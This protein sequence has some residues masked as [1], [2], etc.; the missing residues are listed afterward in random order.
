MNQDRAAEGARSAG[1]RA[2]Q[3]SGSSGA[4]ESAPECRP[5]YREGWHSERRDR[6]PRWFRQCG[7]QRHGTRHFSSKPA[8]YLPS[9]STPL[10]GTAQ[11]SVSLLPTASWKMIMVASKSAAWLEKEAG[12]RCC[13]HFRRTPRRSLVRF[14][15]QRLH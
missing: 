12:S 11:A 8:K 5:G 6:L 15:V 7:G 10:R 2:R 13:C 3:R 1:G 4:S 9:P 14:P